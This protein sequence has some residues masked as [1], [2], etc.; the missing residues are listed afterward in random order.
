MHGPLDEIGLIEV[1]QLLERGGRS[2][3]L[4][5]SG[6][7][8][9]MPR[10][11]LIHAGRVAAIEPDAGDA[12]LE[13]A[14]VRRHLASPED[15]DGSGVDH[16]TRE[17]VRRRLAQRA[18]GTM[19]HWTRG[20]F[21]FSE[22]RTAPGPLD[23]SADA[24]VLTLVEDESRRVALAEALGEWHAVPAFAAPDTIAAG[25]RV[26]LDPL[27]WRILEA[28]DGQRDVAAIAALLEEPLEDVGDRVQALEAAA[29]LQ[30]RSSPREQR[31]APARPMPDEGERDATARRLRERVAQHP[32]DAEGWRALGLAE[33]GAG[34]FDLAIEAWSTWQR[35]APE[36]AD[37]AAMLI[38][39][40]RTMM[41]ALRDSDD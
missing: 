35:V 40:A 1:L 38:L 28:T 22:G 15:R 21:D 18:L 7:D 6:P 33:V 25:D 4:R 36:R 31:Q 17:A 30:L 10:T 12:A 32:E 9:A 34:R 37:D 3:I 26:Q 24:L 41:E 19:L 23:W 8:S 16:A 29:I 20:R 11:V 27:D 39:A 2:G 13:R 14:L 5:V